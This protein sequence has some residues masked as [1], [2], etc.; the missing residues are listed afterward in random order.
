MQ[1][2]FFDLLVLVAYFA[3]ILAVGFWAGRGERTTHDYFLGGRRQHWLVVAFSL[4][5]TEVSALTFLV[6]P[7]RSFEDNC[8]YLQ[9][10]VGSLIGRLLIMVLV[11][12]ALYGGAVTT[13]YEYLGQRFGPWTRTTAA[14]MFFASRIVGSGIR[15]LAA[16]L[17]LSIVFDWPLTWV[18]IA[19]TSVAVLYSTFGGIKAIIWTDALQAMVFLGGALAALV[20]IFLA[21]PGAWTENLASAYQA[22]KFH[23]FEWDW[24]PNNDKVFWV[25]VIHATI[26]N[27]A[28]FGADQDLTQ[29]MLTCPDVRRAQRSLLFNALAG[30]PIV[31]L[32]LLL[33]TLLFVYYQSVP[34]ALLPNAEEA[35]PDRIFSHFIATAMPIGIGLKGLLVAGIFA[36]AMSSLDSALGALSATAVTDLYRPF[37]AR[38]G[39][40][41]FELWV[42]RGCT[43]LFGAILA[44]V[45][46]GFADSRQLLEDAFGWVGLL[47]G[48]ILGVL[49]LG[50]TTRARGNDRVN[51]VAMVSSVLVL[52]AIKG[53]QERAETIYV[54][55]P[56]WIVIGTAWTYSIAL[57][58]TAPAP[59]KD[60]ELP[61][62]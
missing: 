34:Q 1:L 43:V 21:I 49:L 40:E 8:W 26:Q 61:V 58:W 18:V 19:A 37:M 33:G 56:W 53:L 4:V 14:L 10:Y 15:L 44:V 41:T 30:L 57:C 27:M 12:P 25:L 51:T 39:G 20:F 6:V 42:A 59:R 36:A 45:A 48:G 54:A 23:T 38:R 3:G 52:V 46:L 7:G 11:L 62:P 2:G 29:R 16:S 55:W 28:A 50:I 17:A 31:C 24:N 5:A 60:T 22:G 47:F 9:M 13:V 32:F 35:A